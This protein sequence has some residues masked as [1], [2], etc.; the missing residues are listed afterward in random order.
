MPEPLFMT[1]APALL[2][3]LLL[4]STTLSLPDV[5]ATVLLA[6]TL[7][8]PLARKESVASVPAVL[9]TLS[10]TV[11]WLPS[12]VKLPLGLPMAPMSMA[13][14]VVL[15]V[16]SLRPKATVPAEMRANSADEMPS[17]SVPLVASADVPPTSS[18]VDAVRVCTVTVPV[19]AFSVVLLSM[20]KLSVVSVTAALPLLATVPEL[21]R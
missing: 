20:P 9:V 7:M 8:S 4:L 10:L 19:P 2:P 1:M 11:M 21:P 13:L 5:D 3:S 18:K 14:R 17:L 15:A 16:A 6:A 12:T